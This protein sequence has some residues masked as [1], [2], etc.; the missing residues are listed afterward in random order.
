MDFSQSCIEVLCKIITE[1]IKA[2]VKYLFSS[3]IL[4][5][6]MHHRQSQEMKSSICSYM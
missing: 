3:K 4:P 1:K 6:T 5:Q 2:T